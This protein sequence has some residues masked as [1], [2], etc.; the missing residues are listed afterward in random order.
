M[1]VFIQT[2]RTSAMIDVGVRVRG[3]KGGACRIMPATLQLGTG[4]GAP[5]ARPFS[6]RFIDGQ[7]Q[8]P[9]NMVEGPGGEML[10]PWVG[11]IR[12]NEER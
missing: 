2:R 5:V 11:A 12:A 6:L 4:R 3:V 9:I 1:N 10:A 7:V 8:R